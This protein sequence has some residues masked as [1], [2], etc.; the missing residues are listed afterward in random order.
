MRGQRTCAGLRDGQY[1][2]CGVRLRR[3]A[4]Q[5]NAVQ[6]PELESGASDREDLDASDHMLAKAMWCST[7]GER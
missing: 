3:A 1:D 2:V 7:D 4:G 5:S 6:Q